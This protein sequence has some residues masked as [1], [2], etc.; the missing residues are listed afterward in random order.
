[1]PEWR[2][3]GRLGGR[4]RPFANFGAPVS[5]S[6]GAGLCRHSIN[7]AGASPFRGSGSG[8]EDEH[9]LHVPGHGHEVPLAANVVDPTQQELAEPERTDLMMPNTGSGV[10]LRSA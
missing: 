7:L 5:R 9:P 10:C 1:M 8:C 2:A 4:L 3:W 6:Q